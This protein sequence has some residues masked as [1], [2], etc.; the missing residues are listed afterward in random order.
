MLKETKDKAKQKKKE[1]VEMQKLEKNQ[2]MLT[3]KR[4]KEMEK[5]N[6]KVENVFFETT[7]LY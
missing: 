7:I 4:E 5:L 6:K 2:A 3:K 1:E